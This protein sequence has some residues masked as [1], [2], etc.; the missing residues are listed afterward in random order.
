MEAA[1]PPHHIVSCTEQSL[2]NLKR[3]SLDLQQLHVWRDEWLHDLS[4][5]DTLRK[6]KEQGKVRAFGVSLNHHEP[7][8]GV[9]LAQ[10]GY[11]DTI[12]VIYNIFDQS[13]AETLFPACREH[14]VGVLVRVPMDEGGLTGSITP[15][16]TFP[17]GDFRSHYFGGTRRAQLDRRVRPLME[18]LGEEAT[19]LPELALRFALAPEAV[20]TVLAGMR[21]SGHVRAN[22]SVS[23][24][25]RL[26]A[27]LLEQLAAHAW[28]RNFYYS[29]PYGVLGMAKWLARKVLKA[30]GLR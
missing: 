21:T 8:S 29:A 2:R 1:F 11:V 9:R 5:L 22:A 24:G 12:Q 15:T 10:S 30:A 13:P 25:R 19:S 3:D 16:T 4:W 7:E 27:S 20:S 18:L 26:S 6:L 14:G 17:P 28:Q 23:D